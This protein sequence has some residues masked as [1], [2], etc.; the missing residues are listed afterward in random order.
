MFGIES[1]LMAHHLDV[2]EEAGLITRSRSSGDG[3]RRYVR[4]VRDA[5][6]ALP[7]SRHLNPQPALFVCTAN[8]ARS[9]L[10]AAL[11][12]SIA[13]APG[14]SAGTRPAAAVHRGAVEAARRHGLDLGDDPR[15]R[16]L[17]A[18]EHPALVV[19]VCDRAHE[20]LGDVEAWHW[21]VAD[22]VPAATSRAFDATVAELR[23]RIVGLLAS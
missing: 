14:A 19:T 8:S 3:R 23:Q 18:V 22:P 9:Q 2:L 6:D 20:E 21:S 13:R 10:A 12:R 5:L 7:T 1:N 15:P 11:W 4:L 16:R 17:D